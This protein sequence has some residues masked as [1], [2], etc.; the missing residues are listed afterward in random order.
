MERREGMK[1]ERE[2]EDGKPRTDVYVKKKIDG[3]KRVKGKNVKKWRRNRKGSRVKRRQR[4]KMRRK[5]C[6]M[7]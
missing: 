2:L 4:R 3:G 7:G 1:K 5:D 6:K